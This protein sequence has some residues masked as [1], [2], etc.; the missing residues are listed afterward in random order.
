MC[1][2]G[3]SDDPEMDADDCLTVKY[4]SDGSQLWTTRYNGTGDAED[5]GNDVVTDGAGNVYVTGRSTGGGTSLDYVT[6]KYVEYDAIRGDA[7]GDE[8]IDLGDAVYLL[9]YLF[10]GDAPPDPLAAGNANCDLVVD[11][12][13]VVY[14]LN[15]LFKGG[16]PPSC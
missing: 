15:Y 13:D 14:L 10:K 6:I 2:T 11:L 3:Y 5:C 1:V 12:A 16:P 9:N 7:N 4:D 8:L